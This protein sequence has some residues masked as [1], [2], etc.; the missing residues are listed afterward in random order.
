MSQ[1]LSLLVLLAAAAAPLGCL[2]Q[3]GGAGSSSSSPQNA[4]TLLLDFRAS[5]S[6]GETVLTSWNGTDP[7]QEAW[8]GV[9]CDGGEVVHL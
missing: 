3:G 8:E 2:A 5:L 1:P 6:N 9:T 4:A 7:C